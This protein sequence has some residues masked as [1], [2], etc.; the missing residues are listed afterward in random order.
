[1]DSEERLLAPLRLL[2][3]QTNMSSSFPASPQVQGPH[4]HPCVWASVCVCSSSCE[5]VKNQPSTPA[6]VHGP[7][8]GSDA[9]V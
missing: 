4:G 7:R 8:M 6:R 3:S 1:M 2:F 9:T 5:M